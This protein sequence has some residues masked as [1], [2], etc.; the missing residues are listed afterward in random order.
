MYKA[1]DK[2]LCI[3]RDPWFED[4]S[5]RRRPIPG[6]VYTAVEGESVDNIHVGFFYRVSTDCLV[7]ACSLAR[8]LHTERIEQDV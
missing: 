7:I 2:L 6:E 3:K 8:T 4:R 1:G 5:L